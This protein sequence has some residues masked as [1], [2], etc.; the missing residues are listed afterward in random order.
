D[1]I[2]RKGRIQ[3]RRVIVA[4]GLRRPQK[5]VRNRAEAG[6]AKQKAFLLGEITEGREGQDVF[7]VDAVSD[8]AGVERRGDL[9]GDVLT[10]GLC[11]EMIFAPLGVESAE[12]PELVLFDRPAQVEA[13][14]EF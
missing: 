2:R 7:L 3:A 11:Q 13:S 1:K 10:E 6:A 9:V 14:V 4:A 8:L 12:E 5:T